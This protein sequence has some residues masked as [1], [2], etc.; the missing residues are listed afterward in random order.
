MWVFLI[1]WL[2]SKGW[3]HLRNLIE[4]QPSPPQAIEPQWQWTSSD[5]CRNDHSISSVWGGT[6]GLNTKSR[7]GHVSG[8]FSSG[9]LC[10][11]LVNSY[12]PEVGG[13]SYSSKGLVSLLHVPF[14]ASKVWT[15]LLLSTGAMA[16]CPPPMDASGNVRDRVFCKSS[17]AHAC[18]MFPGWIETRI[19]WTGNP[20]WQQ[21]LK[22]K[23]EMEA[24][25][26]SLQ[27]SFSVVALQ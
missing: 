2:A 6:V 26:V 27:V 12:P 23:L 3:P 18:H 25:L 24:R 22:S 11:S 14:L 7:R 9:L 16:A 21:S 20:S 8:L 15:C 4:I 19:W 17:N 5:P 1:S 13:L 10:S